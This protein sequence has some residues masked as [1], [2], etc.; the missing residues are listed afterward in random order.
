MRE[1]ISF[2]QQNPIL[3][4][5]VVVWLFSGLASTVGKA[6]KRAQQQRQPGPEMDAD[7][8]RRRQTQA[9]QQQ[10]A[11]PVARGPQNA[12]DIARQLRQMLGLETVEPRTASMERSRGRSD[13]RGSADPSDDD[14]DRLQP[15]EDQDAEADA[16]DEEYVRGKGAHVG[17]LHE[18]VEQRHALPTGVSK[19]V[20]KHLG[21]APTKAAAVRRAPTR[22]PVFDARAAAQAVIALEVLGPPRAERP[23]DAR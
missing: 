21:H 22:R 16:G 19:S 2:F 4:L 9:Q 13:R 3:L 23:Y 20:A 6:A 1:L 17:A 18:E 5:V 10:S 11:E 14:E 7:V 12:E 15:S 8:E